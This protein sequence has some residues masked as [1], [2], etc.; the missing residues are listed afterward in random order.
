M[1]NPIDL[2]PDN[3]R[4]GCYSK[5]SISKTIF[6]LL[7][8]QLLSIFLCPV[9]VCPGSTL[10]AMCPFNQP[11]VFFIF[12]ILSSLLFILYYADTRISFRIN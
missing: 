1:P 3:Y 9:F 4:A 8:S 10:Q 5:R 6:N 7:L 11:F 12:S 2:V